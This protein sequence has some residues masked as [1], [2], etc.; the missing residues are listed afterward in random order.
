[1]NID[2]GKYNAN[3]DLYRKLVEEMYAQNPPITLS[4]EYAEFITNNQLRLL[5]RLARYKFVARMIKPADR[6][7]EVGSGSGLGALFLAQHCAHVT[8]IE[9]KETELDEARSIN[10]RQNVDFVNRDFFTLD[11]SFSSTVIA[12]L[13]VIE[14]LPGPMAPDFIKQAARILPE[15]GMIILGTP[16]FNS[17]P[18]QGALSQASHERCHKLDELVS[19]V[20]TGFARTLTFSMND[21]LV[22]TGNPNMAWY[23][24]VIGLLPRKS[25]KV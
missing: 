18:F 5:I 19:L 8:G 24:F 16:S 15:T 1:M 7:L 6:V 11:D 20:E 10:R 14:H 21:E 9:I 25:I 2:I 4:A 17:Y 23:Y 22:H 12:A 13:D 3:P